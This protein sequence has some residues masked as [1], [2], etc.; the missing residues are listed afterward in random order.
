MVVE[1]LARAHPGQKV[2]AENGTIK[3]AEK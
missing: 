3:A 1:G 2:T